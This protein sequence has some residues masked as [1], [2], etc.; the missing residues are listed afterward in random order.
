MRI[1]FIN[2][3][4]FTLN[5]YDENNNYKL[6]ENYNL[7]VENDKIVFIG[8]DNQLIQYELKKNVYDRIID[9]NENLLMPTFKNAHTHSA[10][11]FLRSYADDLELFSWLNKV[12]PLEKKLDSESIYYFSLLAIM[13]YL[14][15]GISFCADMYFGYD[16]MAKAFMDAGFRMSLIGSFSSNNNIE[17]LEDEYH[18]YNNL[19]NDKNH[20]IDYKMGLHAEHTNTLYNIQKAGEIINKYKQKFFVHVSET[21]KE[22]D[23]CI[24]KYGLTPVQLFDKY[25]LFN[26]GG[27]G[28]HSI[29]LDEKDIQIYKQKNVSVVTNPCSNLK[30]ASG[31]ANL[32]KY[33]DNGVNIT[34][35]TDGPASNNS[36]NMFREMYL[37]TC[38]SKATTLDSASI[39]IDKVYDMAIKNSARLYGHEN[40]D[41]LKIGNLADIVMID[42]HKANLQPINNILSSI[43]Y[44]ASPINVKMTMVNGNILYEDY[45]YNIN[46]DENEVYN[47]CNKLLDRLKED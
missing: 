47:K 18:K 30:L 23:E 36:L 45:K 10:M 38:L 24:E 16:D 26:Y 34:I 37:A 21:K 46:I 28:Y 43:I 8:D 4:I 13:E 3:I 27:G 15:T 44:S 19:E 14:A 25:G 2:A 29:Y 12:Q 6:L 41:S 33:L 7:V 5:D 40:I 17:E 9:C 20:L 35:G 1:K 32:K 31:I 22:T 42:L 39:H 11:T